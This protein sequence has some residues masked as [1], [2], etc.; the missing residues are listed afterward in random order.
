MNTKNPASHPGN[1]RTFTIIWFGQLI[2]ALGSGLSGFALG[3][4]IYERTGSATMF[5]LVVLSFEVP[6]IFFSPVAGA[7]V[8]RWNRR[9]I[10]I[11]CDSAAAI[12]MLGVLLLELNNSLEVWHLLVVAFIGA[13]AGAFQ[14]RPFR[15][16][17]LCWCQRNIWGGPAA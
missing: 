12:L 14:W 9:T 11:L 2:S 16:L 10:L 17:P 4:W 5:A 6:G 8:D 1:L 15:R 3:V 13:I 7:L